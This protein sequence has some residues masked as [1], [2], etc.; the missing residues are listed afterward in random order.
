MY[1]NIFGVFYEKC[2]K[3]EAKAVYDYSMLREGKQFFH[4]VEFFPGFGNM[5]YL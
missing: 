1:H 4:S 2:Q 5:L 3:Y